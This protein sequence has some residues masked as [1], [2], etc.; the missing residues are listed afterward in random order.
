VYSP[1]IQNATASGSPA[2][3]TSAAGEPIIVSSNE[4]GLFVQNQNGS[5]AQIV[6]PDVLISNGVFHIIDN[7]LVETNSNPAQASSA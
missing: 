1:D 7:V 4:T 6:R 3:F 2:N 5:I